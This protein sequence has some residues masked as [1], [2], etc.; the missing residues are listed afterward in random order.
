MTPISGLRRVDEVC[1]YCGTDL[2][3]LRG[4]NYKLA[5]LRPNERTRDHV[6]P[7]CKGGRDTVWSCRMCNAD[8]SHLTLE[9]YRLVI[10]HR[11]GLIRR[12]MIEGGF[13]F[14]GEK[15]A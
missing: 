5:N 3:K 12:D 9:E 13:Q 6:E 2:I 4:P 11:R 15:S 10:M 8:K 14:W 1:F 7:K